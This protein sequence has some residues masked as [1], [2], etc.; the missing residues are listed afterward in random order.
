MFHR[1]LC[2]ETTFSIMT[3]SIIALGIKNVTSSIMTLTIWHTAFDGD[4][5]SVSCVICTECR[6]KS[7]MLNAVMLSV[8]APIYSEGY[9]TQEVIIAYP[10]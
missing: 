7:I 2:G 4:L 8:M 5:V 1:S 6:K 10:F 3:L 9:I